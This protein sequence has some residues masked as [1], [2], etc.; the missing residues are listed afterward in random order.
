MADTD[1]SEKFYPFKSLGHCFSYYN[2][3]NPARA[4]SVNMLEPER[5]HKPTCPDFSGLSPKDLFAGVAFS[6]HAG[7]KSVDRE[8]RR[9]W[10]LRNIGP[11]IYQHGVEDIAKKLGRSIS[12]TYA[13]LKLTNQRIERELVDRGYIPERDP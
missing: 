3:S 10:A 8:H 7:L 5:G 2:E 9:V 4:R 13:A 11:R 12:W 1:Q 6:I